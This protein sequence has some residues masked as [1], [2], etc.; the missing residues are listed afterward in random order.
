MSPRLYYN[1]C[2]PLGST[3]FPGLCPGGFVA[4]L[5]I[6]LFDQISGVFRFCLVDNTFGNSLYYLIFWILCMYVNQMTVKT[7]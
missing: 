7:L 4:T 2:S 6:S 5:S 3:P 1:I